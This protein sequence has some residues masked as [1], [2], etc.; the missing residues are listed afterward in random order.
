MLRSICDWTYYGHVWFQG[1][2]GSRTVPLVE[3]QINEIKIE[4]TSE[5][6]TLKNYMLSVRRLSAKDATLS[7]IKIST[8]TCID[9]EFNPDILEYYGNIYIVLHLRAIPPPP[10]KITRHWKLINA[11]SKGNCPYV[12]VAFPGGWGWPN[13]YSEEGERG[14]GV[15]LHILTI[16]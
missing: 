5:D 15:I 6:G 7:D 13:Q 2:G 10:Q 4:V 8:G 12:K 1:S 3:G 14:G 16:S 9:P 11:S